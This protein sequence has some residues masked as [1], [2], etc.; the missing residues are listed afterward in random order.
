MIPT[1]TSK[2]GKVKQR[3]IE[4]IMRDDHLAKRMFFIGCQGLPVLWFVN[5]LHFCQKVYGPTPC[6]DSDDNGDNAAV[7]VPPI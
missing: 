1:K 3:V 6:L 5:V 2:R 7:D 4:T